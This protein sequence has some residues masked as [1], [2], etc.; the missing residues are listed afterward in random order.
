MEEKK[1]NN[2]GM[3]RL[4]EALHNKSPL[5]SLRTYQGDMA[6]FIKEKNESV[7]SV[8]VKEK[9][10]KEKEEEKQKEENKKINPEKK[11]EN[12]APFH[13]NVTIMALSFLLV[14]G[15]ALTIMYVFELIKKSPT[16][17]VDTQSGKTIIPYN[18]SV[19]I[20][21]VTNETLI[22]ELKKLSA[23]N[24]ITNLKIIDSRGKEVSNSK[25]FF[26]FIAAKTPTDLQR[27][28]GND[29]FF[30]FMNQKSKLTPFV[31]IKVNDFGIAFSSMLEWENTL[32]D[33]FDFLNTED[34]RFTGAT[35]TGA[36]DQTFVWKDVIAKN[37]DARTF[38]NSKGVSKVTYTFLD[39]NTILITNNMDTVGEVSAI[40]ISRSFTR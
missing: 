35:T 1:E 19:S 34:P 5:P 21:N 27:T 23:G 2:N 29:F 17:Q 20:S 30:G 11:P 33:D 14:I 37:K 8:A 28:L 39:K 12:K 24:G 38:M 25:D 9:V 15:G 13:I 32:A 36:V 40:Y 6:E 31:I 22:P 7:L 4:E 10:R 16:A 18:N 3:K 26:Y